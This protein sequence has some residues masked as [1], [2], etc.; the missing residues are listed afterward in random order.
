MTNKRQKV[1]AF[2]RELFIVTSKRH[3]KTNKTT[4]TENKTLL[5]CGSP[6]K[7]YVFYGKQGQRGENSSCARIPRSEYYSRIIQGSSLFK[8]PSS[9]EKNVNQ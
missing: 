9:T 3:Y 5:W 2:L 6:V 8:T 1:Y 4:L 7:K